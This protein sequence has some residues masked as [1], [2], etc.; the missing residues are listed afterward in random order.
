MRD[1]QGMKTLVI[2]VW[3]CSAAACSAQSAEQ[4]P[5][6]A[7]L[8]NL[9]VVAK[10]SRGQAVTD[11][12]RDDFQVFEGSKAQR[13]V[14]FRRN[15]QSVKRV[16]RAEANEYSN[17]SGVPMERVT[18]ILF[19]LLN[20]RFEDRGSMLHDLGPALG[21]VEASETLF[22][23]I[24]TM[25]GTLYAVHGL[26]DGDRGT[27]AAGARPWTDD[28]KALLESASRELFRLRSLGIDVDTRV[29]MTYQALGSLANLVAAAPGR[30]SLIWISHGVPISLGLGNTIYSGMD[31]TPLLQRLTATLDRADVA[32]YTVRQPE[33]LAPGAGAA[34]GAESRSGAPADAPGITLATE[35]TL[36]QFA[37]LTG[38][39]A[40]MT[41]DIRGAIARAASDARMSY[42]IS[43]EPPL[44]NWDGKYHKIRVTCARKGV[45][46]ETKQGYY[47]FANLAAEGDREKAAL[48]AA[49]A[50]AFNATEIGLYVRLTEHEPGTL[51]V[52]LA[53]RVD[54]GDVSLVQ[55][56]ELATGRL[57]VSVV[58]YMKD[59]R[60]E[61][62]PAEEVVPKLTAEQREKALHE[63]IAV[64]E[65]LVVAEGVE[66]LRVLVYDRGSGAVGSLG[67]PL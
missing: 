4:P 41:P 54:A 29:R 50:S 62:F 59:G 7:P 42:R 25:N 21:H 16:M 33:S 18:V 30:K 56:G 47:A 32:V 66:R 28:I 51:S 2:A 8:V 63:G 11:L 39:Y 45:K 44:G 61:L 26:P 23:Y 31:Y 35:A 5:A 9:N 27:A 34:S 55:A 67:I 58:G 37:Q 43:Y 64:E 22:F 1:N 24:L 15:E 12:T 38:G 19:D 49:T 13:V 14:A 53:I 10:D 40:F 36:E 52:E 20:A 65:R 57:A 3:I 48:E 46:L 6:A 60:T 17:R